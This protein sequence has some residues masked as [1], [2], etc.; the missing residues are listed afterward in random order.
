LQAR[1]AEQSLRNMQRLVIGGTTSD[2]ATVTGGTR[3]P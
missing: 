3:A 2:I 1:F